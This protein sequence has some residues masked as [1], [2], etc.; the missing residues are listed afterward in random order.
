[1]CPSFGPWL[2]PTNNFPDANSDP[3]TDRPSDRPTDGPTLSRRGYLKIMFPALS[4]QRRSY[5]LMN[6]TEN[7]LCTWKTDS[8]VS[9]LASKYK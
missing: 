6:I 4:M 8:Q 9:K 7:V 2:F 3:T 1:M 5:K